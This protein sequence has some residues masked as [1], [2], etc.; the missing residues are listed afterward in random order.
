M[1]NSFHEAKQALSGLNHEYTATSSLGATSIFGIVH[2]CDL[3]LRDL[4][5]TAVGSSF[6]QNKFKPSHQPESLSLKLGVNSYYTSDSQSLLSS[7]TGL[8]L[9]NARYPT[10]QAYSNYT[11]PKSV[12]LAGELLTRA[13]AFVAETEALSGR[14][15]VLATVRSHS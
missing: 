8:S 4:Y 3:A 6:P 9:A 5:T 2:A 14:Q 13:K 7:L 12:G 10:S 15:E 11:S 1:S